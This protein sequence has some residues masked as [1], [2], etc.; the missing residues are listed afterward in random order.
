MNVDFD[1]SMLVHGLHLAVCIRCTRVNVFLPMS[2][3]G[4]RVRCCSRK[5]APSNTPIIPVGVG[6]ARHTLMSRDPPPLFSSTDW[7]TRQRDSPPQKVR[8]KRLFRRRQQRLTKPR[9]VG[10][11]RSPRP[12]TD[13][14]DDSPQVESPRRRRRRRR[15]RRASWRC[16]HRGRG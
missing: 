14:E 2:F 6:I 1:L 12:A 13:E 3:T 16:C 7:S 15:R 8:R 10:S 4:A 11:S 9:F 5:P